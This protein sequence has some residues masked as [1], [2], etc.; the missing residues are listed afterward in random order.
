MQRI[1]EFLDE[2]EVPDWASSL[3]SQEHPSANDSSGTVGFENATFQWDVAPRNEQVRFTLGPLNL[4]FPRPGLSLVS[5]PTGSGKSAVLNALLG[6]K[7]GLSL[8]IYVVHISH[9]ISCRNGLYNWTC[10]LEQS[11]AQCGVLCSE[12]LC[13]T[14]VQIF[15]T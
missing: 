5:G 15:L 2:S 12:S 3:K 14:F 6:G 10:T 1:E 7:Y 11:R 9:T 4:A 8:S 13:V